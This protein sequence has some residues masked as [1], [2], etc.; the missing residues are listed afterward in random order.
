MNIETDVVKWQVFIS[1]RYRLYQI[2]MGG[3]ALSV[4]LFDGYGEFFNTSCWSSGLLH[5]K[6]A[7]SRK[8]Q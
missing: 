2:D 7:Y 6:N 3:M 4:V 1:K 5:R 8:I